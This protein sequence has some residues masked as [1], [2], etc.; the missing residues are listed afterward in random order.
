MYAD[1]LLGIATSAE[2][3]QDLILTPYQH[4]CSYCYRANVPKCGVMIFGR[5][6]VDAHV[7][8]MC[9]DQEIPSV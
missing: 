3:L 2:D 8:I 7:K 9:V 1:Y 6:P 4:S 5:A